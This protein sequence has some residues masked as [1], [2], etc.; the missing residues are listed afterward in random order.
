M[1]TIREENDKFY[2]TWV[3]EERVLTM[4]KTFEMKKDD[5]VTLPANLHTFMIGLGWKF[6]G[7]FNH[8]D[9]A[10]ICLDKNKNVVQTCNYSSNKTKGIENRGDLT[11][12]E[13]KKI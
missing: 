10:C 12:G 2:D 3:K 13:Y 6:K 5:V 9:P 8:I 1:D 7:A 4:D 11:E